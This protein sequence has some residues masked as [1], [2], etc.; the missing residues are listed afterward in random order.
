MAT[1]HPEHNVTCC[2]GFDVE[3]I[4]DPDDLSVFEVRCAGCEQTVCFIIDRR[5]TTGED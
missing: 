1:T 5:S 4:H 3:V 2:D